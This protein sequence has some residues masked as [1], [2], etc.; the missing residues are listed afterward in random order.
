M[1]ILKAVSPGM[2]DTLHLALEG[3]RKIKGSSVSHVCGKRLYKGCGQ[4]NDSVIFCILA[5]RAVMCCVCAGNRWT[6]KFTDHLRR[7]EIYLP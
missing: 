3:A 2:W 1:N 7:D 6:F 4:S 5:S